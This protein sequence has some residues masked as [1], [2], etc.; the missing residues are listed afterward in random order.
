MLWSSNTLPPDKFLIVCRRG[1]L[2]HISMSPRPLIEHF[3]VLADLCH[4]FSSAPRSP[5]LNHLLLESVK[6]AFRGGVVPAVPLAT[7]G[8]AD[9]LPVHRSMMAA[10]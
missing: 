1:G 7:H 10:R 9:N 8:V 6:E 3:D 4:G 5:V 2:A